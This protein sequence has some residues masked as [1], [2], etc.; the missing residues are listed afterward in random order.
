VHAC[1]NS[2]SSYT[3][4]SN[5]LAGLSQILTY[6]YFYESDILIDLLIVELWRMDLIEKRKLTDFDPQKCKNLDR[7]QRF[8]IA[9]L[10]LIKTLER[11]ER[12]YVATN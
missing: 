11:S 5:H 12:T 1:C 8:I 3:T 7:F 6:I 4:R 2:S 9:S 10:E